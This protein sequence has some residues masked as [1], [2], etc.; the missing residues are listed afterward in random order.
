MNI[1]SRPLMIAAGISFGVQLVFILL[2]TI[3][4]LLIQLNPEILVKFFDTGG[5]FS[6]PNGAIIGGLVGLG[7]LACLCPF[8]LDMITGGVYAVLHNRMDDIELQD[9]ILGGAASAALGR[10]VA[11]VVSSAI[12]LLMLPMMMNQ[13]TPEFSPS[14]MPSSGISTEAIIMMVVGSAFSA[15]LSVVIGAISGAVMGAIGGG[16]TAAILEHQNN[17]IP[18]SPQNQSQS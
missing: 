3:P 5:D 14:G 12:S 16:I 11:T 6:E 10:I 7:V 9:G 8:I 13:I 15:I 1:K 17:V 4:T 2:T 18:L